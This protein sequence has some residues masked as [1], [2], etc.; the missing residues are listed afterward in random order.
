ML[1]NCTQC[2]VISI[3]ALNFYSNVCADGCTLSNRLIPSFS[4]PDVPIKEN[5]GRP[6]K[7]QIQPKNSV[8]VLCVVNIP[9][10]KRKRNPTQM[11]FT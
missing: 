7:C 2:I 6:T 11:R 10:I 8:W 3:I 9:T 4:K 1:R 5:L